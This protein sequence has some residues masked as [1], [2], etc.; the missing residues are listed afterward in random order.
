MSNIYSDDNR[1]V[2]GPKDDDIVSQERASEMLTWIHEHKP[3]VFGAAL[4]HSYG[5]E[6]APEQ[7]KRTRS[8][9]KN[10]AADQAPAMPAL[11][12]ATGQHAKT[13]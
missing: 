2:C 3:E 10:K 8:P 12:V 5:I 9:N 11:S 1:I 13:G 4:C 7:P 6:P